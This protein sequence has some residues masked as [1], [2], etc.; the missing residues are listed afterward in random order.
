MVKNEFD[1]MPFVK[2][3]PLMLSIEVDELEIML[4]SMLDRLSSTIALITQ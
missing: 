2:T 1:F 4:D 3:S